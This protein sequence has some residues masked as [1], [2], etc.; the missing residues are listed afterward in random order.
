C[1]PLLRTSSPTA[2][3]WRS[4]E[5]TMPWRARTGCAAHAGREVAI[6]RRANVRRIP[7]DSTMWLRLGDGESSLRVRL[8]AGR[9]LAKRTQLGLGGVGRPSAVVWMTKRTQFWAASV[10]RGDLVSAT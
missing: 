5:T 6:S 2:V 3:A 7:L 10:V 4:R 1:P 9:W 8:V